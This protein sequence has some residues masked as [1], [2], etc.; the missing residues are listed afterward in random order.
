MIRQPAVAGQFYSGS[1]KGLK[2]QVE[3]CLDLKAR[4]VEA[5]GVVCPHAGLMYSGPVAGAVYSSISEPDTFIL[6]GPNHYGVGADFAIATEGVWTTPLGQSAVDSILA[7]ELFKNSGSLEEDAFSQGMDHSIE[8]QLPFIQY[9]FRQAQIVPISMKHYDAEEHFL[10]LCQGIG[11]SVA[12]VLSRVKSKTTIV[13]SSDFTHYEPQDVARRNDNA[14]LEAILAL[15]EVRLFKEVA[16]R[17]ISM[18]GY[19]PIAAMLVACKR[20]GA[21][22]GRLVKYMTSGDTTGDYSQVVGYAGVIIT[23]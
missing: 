17:G 20:L 10:S 5:L 18:C 12:A 23:K 11:E 4:K 7:R 1:V 13:A 15:D 9:L 21:K 19:A 8:V 14:A 6:F 2:E 3:S 22:N 16:E